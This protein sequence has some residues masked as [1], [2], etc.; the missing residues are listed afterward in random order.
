MATGV[1]EHGRPG[2]QEVLRLYDRRSGVW[3][4]VEEAEGYIVARAASSV[5]IAPGAADHV[6][7]QF[8]TWPGPGTYVLVT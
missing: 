2:M 5:S 7:L 4:V 3:I 1:I 6:P 8:D